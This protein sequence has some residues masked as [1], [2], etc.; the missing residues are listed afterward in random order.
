MTTETNKCL[1]GRMALRLLVQCPVHGA[2]PKEFVEV[3]V[4]RDEC[5]KVLQ[6]LVDCV[7][8]LDLKTIAARTGTSAEITQLT[9]RYLLQCLLVHSNGFADCRIT[10]HGR[11]ILDLL[12]KEQQ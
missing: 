2:K 9:L 7:E 6:V 12:K 1:C 5:F 3:Q 10:T 8:Y 11:E 4:V